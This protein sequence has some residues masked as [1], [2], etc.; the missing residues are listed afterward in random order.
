MKPNPRLARWIDRLHMA[1]IVFWL[2]GF[3]FYG[4]PAFRRFHAW[5]IVAG[6]VHQLFLGN[7]CILT[8]WSDAL[9]GEQ[10]PEKIFFADRCLARCG[11][12]YP[13]W[14]NTLLTGLT[15]AAAI[16]TLLFWH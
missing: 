5:F 3:A 9:Y 7:R 2:A 11:I 6:A 4:F 14:L 1:V 10:K 13:H 16:A 8:V 15:I 12:I